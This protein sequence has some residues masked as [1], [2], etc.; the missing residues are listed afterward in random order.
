MPALAVAVWFAASQ[1][2]ESPYFPPLS[3]IL[4]IIPRDF[5]AAGHLVSDLL[6]SLLVVIAGVAIAAAVGIVGGYLI[7][8][9]RFALA[10]TRPV[11]DAFR[12]VPAV[13]LVPVAIVILGP[14][15][16]SEI[17]L[18]SLASLW[19]ILLNTIAGVSGVE[20]TYKEVARLSRLS[21]WDRFSRIILPAAMPAIMAGIH[22]SIGLAVI[23][24]VTMEMFAS[25]E[26]IGRYLINAQR[27]FAIP[28]SFAGAIVVGVMGYLLAVAFGAFERFALRWYF[29]RQG[30]VHAKENR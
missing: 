28:V 20:P 7:A 25:T 3:M 8:Q 15:F 27:S 12:A 19:P 2:S 30:V 10:V 6:P 16:S 22:T 21:A 13:A 29:E 1:G 11:I 23:V 17:A 4:S 5:I 24:M 9:S 26:G 18:V 14:G